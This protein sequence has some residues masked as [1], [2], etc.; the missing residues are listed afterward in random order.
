MSGVQCGSLSCE[1]S[2]LNARARSTAIPKLVSF[3]DWPFSKLRWGRLRIKGKRGAEAPLEVCCGS[4]SQLELEREREL[5]LTR[6]GTRTFAGDRTSRLNI[7]AGVSRVDVVE[8]V[9]CI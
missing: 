7:A 4:S 3:P 1:K 9:F 8:R 5:Q 6:S 2:H